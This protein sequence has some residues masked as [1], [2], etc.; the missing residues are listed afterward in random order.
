MARLNP[1]QTSSSTFAIHTST[2]AEESPQ[3]KP[4]TCE[5]TTSFIP[6]AVGIV[7]LGLIG[8]SFAKALCQDAQKLYLFNRNQEVMKQACADC[9]ALVL[10]NENISKC[11]LII[12]AAYP[13]ANE[14]WLEQHADK[15]SP[16]ALVIDTGGV[17]RTTCKRCFAL[18]H[19]YQWEF[20]GCHPMAGTQYSGFAHARA[21]MFHHAPMVVVFPDSYSSRQQEQLC[22]RLQNL[23]ASCKF[24]SYRCTNAQFHDQQIAYTSQLAHVVSNAY[25][26]SPAAQAH[27]GFSA[28]SYKDLTRVARLNA[29]MWTELFL[30][31]K[32]N[33]SHEISLMISHLQ[34]Y[35]DALDSAD[36]HMLHRLLAEGDALKKKAEQS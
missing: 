31:N 7:G 3:N 4:S 19:D 27:K 12:L 9:H 15:I 32:D 34:E 23:L 36:E 35:K 30:A 25:V 10:D 14:T 11:E 8:G 21:N 22:S 2:R 5:H 1:Q 20:I 33:L 29:D 18:A 24:G 17:K 6:G 26:K 28:G 13:H 16:D